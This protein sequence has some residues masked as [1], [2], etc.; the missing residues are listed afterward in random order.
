MKTKNLVSYYDCGHVCHH[1]ERIKQNISDKESSDKEKIYQYLMAGTSVGGALIFFWDEL[2][3]PPVE[4][5]TY[6][7]LSDGVWLWSTTLIYYFYHYNLA[8]PLDF[9]DHMKEQS[10]VCHQL[11]EEEIDS[12]N[13]YDLLFDEQ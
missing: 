12:I 3:N 7:E 11:T 1:L 6:D 5:D 8:L 4:I 13:F 2:K 9:L 10:W